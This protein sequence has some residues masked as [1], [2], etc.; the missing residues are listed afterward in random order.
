MADSHSGIL[1]SCFFKKWGAS[2]GGRGRKLQNHPPFPPPPLETHQLVSSLICKDSAVECLKRVV[3]WPSGCTDFASIANQLVQALKIHSW[4][5]AP[6][7]PPKILSWSHLQRRGSENEEQEIVLPDCARKEENGKINMYL[8]LFF[9]LKAV[10]GLVT[11]VTK[12]SV[13][14]AGCVGGVWGCGGKG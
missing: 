3:S 10:V 6:S 4:T 8:L 7:L 2:L 12:K 1:Y 11:L 5:S 13:L 14:L 9:F